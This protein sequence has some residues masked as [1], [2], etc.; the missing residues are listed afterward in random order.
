MIAFHLARPPSS[1]RIPSASGGLRGRSPTRA[2]SPLQRGAAARAQEL[3]EQAAEFA[4]RRCER[5]TERSEA[6]DVAMARLRGDETYRLLLA[7]AERAE[8]RGHG[9]QG[10]SPLRARGRGRHPD[11]RGSRPTAARTELARAM[12]ARARRST[13]SPPPTCEAQLILDQAWI[14]WRFDRPERMA[15]TA[16]EALAL[17]RRGGDPLLLSSAL[18]A[19]AAAAW[20]EGRYDDAVDHS[21]E[22]VELLDSAPNAPG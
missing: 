7:A 19:A 11:E 16:A 2:R 20:A 10:G 17:A 3:L 14:M 22:R 4:A 6:A 8:R 9:A 5:A 12:L 18:D 13:P 15:E 1:T 21:R